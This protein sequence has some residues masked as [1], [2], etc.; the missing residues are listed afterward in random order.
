MCSQKPGFF[1]RNPVSRESQRR[2]VRHRRHLE[3]LAQAGQQPR[4]VEAGQV[5]DAA[6]RGQ[7][8][9]A[10]VFHAGG[11]DPGCVEGQRWLPSGGAGG[12]GA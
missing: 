1:R 11:V 7:D 3:M 8:R 2:I 10:G 9:D 5:V 4:R 6:M 12:T